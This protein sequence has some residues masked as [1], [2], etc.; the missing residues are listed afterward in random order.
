[1]RSRFPNLAIIARAHDREH[2]MRLVEAGVDGAVRE[3]F[4]GAVALGRLALEKLGTDRETVE[5]VADEIMR[6]DAE[7]MALQIAAGDVRAGEEQVLHRARAWPRPAPAAQP[8]ATAAEPAAG[9]A[10]RD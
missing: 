7:R 3:L 10:E 5:A 9:A 4:L 6:R 8:A 1:V 2:Y